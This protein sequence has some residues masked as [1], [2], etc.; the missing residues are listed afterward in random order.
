MT[1][2]ETGSEQSLELKKGDRGGDP[3]LA[4]E[5]HWQWVSGCMTASDSVASEP[6]LATL[7][8]CSPVALLFPG[9]GS[10]QAPLHSSHSEPL[11]K[12]LSDGS[13]DWVIQEGSLLTCFVVEPA[14]TAD[15]RARM[16]LSLTYWLP[17]SGPIP[18]STHPKREPKGGCT[19]CTIQM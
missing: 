9:S 2:G 6:Q 1:S 12:L 7:E 13:C 14:G 3:L 4:L 16:W 15:W 10:T 8:N 11:L 5:V 19:A 18:R 17:R